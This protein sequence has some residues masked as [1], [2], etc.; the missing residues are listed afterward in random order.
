MKIHELYDK[1]PIT[2]G[3]YLSKC[4]VKDIEE[5]LHPSG[6]YL[7]NWREYEDVVYG[8]KE[9]EFWTK[10]DNEVTIFIIQDGDTDGIC[11]TVILYQYL[12]Q[13]S[14]KWNIKI[15]IHNPKNKI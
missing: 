15:L 1:E 3:S 10:I 6:K 12:T 4:G 7:D 2:V 9:I 8:I 5:Y 14:D 11:S 13:L